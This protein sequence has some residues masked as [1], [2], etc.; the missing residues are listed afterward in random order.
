[1]NS[2]I[3]IPDDALDSGEMRF[4]RISLES[5]TTPTLKAI[6]GRLAVKKRRLLII[7]L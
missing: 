6:S 2:G 1:M 5:S 3:Y 7:L 4:L